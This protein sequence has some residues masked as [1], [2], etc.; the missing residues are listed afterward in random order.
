MKQ[1]FIFSLF[2]LCA[3]SGG[4]GPSSGKISSGSIVSDA[5]TKEF[6]HQSV[7]TIPTDLQLSDGDKSYIKDELSLTQDESATLEQI[8]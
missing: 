2:L 8:K 4:G 1:S 5:A 6:I 7:Q 3:C